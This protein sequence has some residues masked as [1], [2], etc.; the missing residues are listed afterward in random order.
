VAEVASTKGA[1]GREPGLTPEVCG[2]PTSKWRAPANGPIPGQTDLH[3]DTAAI[4]EAEF[5][6]AVSV[7]RDAP[8]AYNDEPLVASKRG[9]VR[10]NEALLG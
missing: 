8:A 1:R 7:A 6:T 4:A 5:R 2:P 3:D 9:G 10:R